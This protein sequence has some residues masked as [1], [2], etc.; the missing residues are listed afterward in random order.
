MEQSS[1]VSELLFSL[2][3]VSRYK[4]GLLDINYDPNYLKMNDQIYLLTEGDRFDL[5]TIQPTNET[6]AFVLENFE[7]VMELGKIYF[8]KPAP[9]SALTLEKCIVKKYISIE[10]ITMDNVSFSSELDFAEQRL[11]DLLRT[12]IGTKRLKMTCWP[13]ANV[14]L[15]TFLKYCNVP[16]YIVLKNGNDYRLFDEDVDVETDPNNSYCLTEFFKKKFNND[17]NEAYLFEK[18]HKRSYLIKKIENFYQPQEYNGSSLTSGSIVVEIEHEEAFV[19]FNPDSSPCVDEVVLP[20][21]SQK[22]NPS[23]TL[24]DYYLT[25][26]HYQTLF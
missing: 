23:R 2:D 3:K 13:F 10:N 4:Y 19:I 14:A 24:T 22:N 6:V 25:N 18:S 16:H 7:L 17:Q 21:E 15:D 5:V 9:Q 11:I 1:C 20:L 26:W 8:L 12:E